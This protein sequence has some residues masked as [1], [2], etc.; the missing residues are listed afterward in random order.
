MSLRLAHVTLDCDDPGVV[1]AFWSAALDRPIDPDPN[2]FFVSIG[3]AGHDG[4]AWFFIKVPEPKAAKNRMHVD[5]ETDD[6]EKEIARLLELGATRGADH[7]EYGQSWTVM[8]DPEA[9]EFC[10]AGP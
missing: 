8:A 3:I 6:R 10:I 2:E 9:N 5:L 4:P 7:D 1:A